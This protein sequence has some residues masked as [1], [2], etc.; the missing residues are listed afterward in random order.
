MLSYRRF[1][2]SFLVLF[3]IPKLAFSALPSTVGGKPV[4]SIA[5]ML[6]VVTPAV[7]DISVSGKKQTNSDI[8]DIFGQFFGFDPRMQAQEREFQGIGSGVIIDASKGYIITN[9]HVIESADQIKVTL[10]NG[11]EVDAKKIG[12]DK[13]SDLA[14]LQIKANNLIQIKKANSDNL[15][16]GDFVVAIGNPFGVGQ[17]VTSGIISALGRSGLNLENYE[18][19]IQTDAA[20]NSGNSGGALINLQGELVGINTAI[21]AAG[22]GNVGI[23]FAIPINMVDSMITQF[24][25][26]GEIKRGVL[27]ISGGEL[28][29][30][31]AK[32]FG[33]NS[34]HG[35]FVQQV[36]ADSAAQKAGIKAGDIIIKLDDQPIKTFSELRAKIGTKGAGTEVELEIVR[37]GKK[38]VL[39]VVL[40]KEVKT[41]INA[42][43]HEKLKSVE[44]VNSTKD[45][46]EGVEVSN[47]HPRSIAYLSGLRKGDIII[48]INNNK[49]DNLQML[50][51]ILEKNNYDL[52]ALNISRNKEE[53]YLVIR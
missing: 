39:T 23:G 17:T 42:D 34:T 53:L 45:N 2:F 9:F 4:I 20:I 12:S 38:D 16:V 27:G 51:D 11:Q 33:Y 30:D 35:A 5:P 26:H 41:K 14:L 36:F 19:F 3:L 15:E 46:K 8:P 18:N 40:E 21:L 49:I 28:S 31:L 52:L 13:R 32:N 10:S 43:L 50:T 6:K 44:L 29:S 25:E 37:N 48:G 1:A 22:G 24:I 47:L 7:V